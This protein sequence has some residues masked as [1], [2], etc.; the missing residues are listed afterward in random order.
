MTLLISPVIGLLLGLHGL[1]A[2]ALLACGLIAY[3]SAI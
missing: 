1:V 3:G 2:W